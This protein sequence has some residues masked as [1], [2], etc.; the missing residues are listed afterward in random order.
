MLEDLQNSLLVDGD[1]FGSQLWPNAAD[2]SR[3]Q[4]LF[5]AL[6]RSRMSRF[7]FV[8][9]ELLPVLPVDNPATA[10]LDMLPSRDGC[11]IADYRDE[12]I[13]SLDL[14]PQDGKAVLR[15]MVGNTFDESVQVFGHE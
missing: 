15:V 12:I 4:I 10:R 9:F 5:D 1:D 8:G 6:C 14:H 3:R 2:C 7:Q 13:S 11:C